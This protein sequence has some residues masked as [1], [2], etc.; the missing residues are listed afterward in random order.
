M[1]IEQLTEDDALERVQDARVVAIRWD[2]IPFAVVLDLDLAIPEEKDRVVRR[3]W[4]VFWAISVIDFGLVGRLPTGC[5]LTS[6]MSRSEEPG[7]FF[8]YRI[9]AVMA[10]FNADDSLAD[11][12]TKVVCVSAKRLVA[13]QSTATAVQD[14]YGLL[15]W[16]QRCRLASDA[17]FIEAFQRIEAT[18]LNQ[19]GTSSENDQNQTPSAVL[20]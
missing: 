10:I 17:E 20:E 19:Q 14:Q 5:C 8:A 16:E 6:T 12:C 3:A 18:Q 15:S 9:N 11:G 13:L 1:G 2:V 4:Y 7:G